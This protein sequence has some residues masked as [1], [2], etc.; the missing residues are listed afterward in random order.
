ML[1]V[2]IDI[3]VNFHSS[4]LKGKTADLL[5]H[6]KAAGLTA[7]LATGTSLQSS[8]LASEL[9][10][11]EPGYVWATAGVHPHSAKDWSS[12]VEAT[13]EQLWKLPSTVAIGEAGLDYNRM[14]SP[15]ESQKHAFE[16]Q[17]DAALRTGKP[18]FLHCRDAF[19]DFR[20]MTRAAARD[21]ATGVVHCFTGTVAEAR[22]HLDDGFDLGI[23]GWVA[24]PARGHALREAV[25]VIPLERMHL[26]T[27]AP[28]LMPRNIPKRGPVNVPANLV[29]VARAVAEIKGVSAEEVSHI[30][31]QNSRRM[32]SL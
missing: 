31:E 28:Y 32:F 29:W 14:F 10:A 9:A 1:H 27:D 11:T 3:G 26:E 21:G 6:A 23:T 22:A 17:L 16:R 5:R 15:M 25:R 19:E 30:C 2:M 8:R 13:L 18:L 7:I 24:D 12:A 20:D 4:Q